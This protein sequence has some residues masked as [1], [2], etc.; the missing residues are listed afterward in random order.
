MGNVHVTCGGVLF[1]GSG[2]GF[3]MQP[4]KESGRGV[5][6]GGKGKDWHSAEH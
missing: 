3:F 6:V 4:R 2:S 5:T 1:A